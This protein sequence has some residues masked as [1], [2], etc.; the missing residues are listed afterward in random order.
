MIYTDEARSWGPL[1]KRFKSFTINH[2]ERYVDGHITTNR[3]ESFFARLRRAEMGQH[4]SIAGKYLDNYADEMAWREDNRR[5]SNGEQF[6]ILTKFAAT[7]GQS[8]RWAGYWQNHYPQAW[9]AR[10]KNTP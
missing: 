5:M 3:V 7:L 6:Q 1:H 2:T 4:H 9:W 8:A 10:N